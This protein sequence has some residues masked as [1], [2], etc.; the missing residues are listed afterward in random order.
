MMLAKVARRVKKLLW[1]DGCLELYVPERVEQSLAA[2][3]GGAGTGDAG[4]IPRT[5]SGLRASEYFH[6]RERLAAT[7]P[8]QIREIP[9]MGGPD[10]IGAGYPPP[11]TLRLCMSTRRPRVQAQKGRHPYCDFRLRRPSPMSWS[12]SS[13]GFARTHW[14]CCQSPATTCQTFWRCC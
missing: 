5:S 9:R 6:D 10:G 3:T 14:R 7:E 4:D 11:V 2:G 12:R 1:N 8:R 13:P